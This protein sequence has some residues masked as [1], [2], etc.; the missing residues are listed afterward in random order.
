MFI[1]THLS[2]ANNMAETAQQNSKIDQM[3]FEQAL[4]ELEGIVQNLES[5]KA[6]LEKSISAYER[7]VALKKHCDK[8]L[9]QAQSKIEKI[10]IDDSGNISSQEIPDMS[11]DS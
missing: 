8:K 3:T 9:K 2:L 7:G 4:E 10:T 11:Q 6:P 5:G 1:G